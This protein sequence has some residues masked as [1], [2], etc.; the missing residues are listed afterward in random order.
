[1]ENINKEK[2]KDV[3]L[4]VRKSYRLLFEYQSRILNLAKY[5]GDYFSYSYNGG[6]PLYSAACPK[7]GKGSLDN[8]AWDWLN[9]YAYAFHFGEKQIKEQR[10]YFEIRIYS[11]TGFY[12]SQIKEQLKTETFLDE[13]SSK[14]KI[15]LI[16]SNLEWDPN[17]L[18]ENFNSE[19]DEYKMKNEDINICAKSYDLENFLDEEATNIILVNFTDY[20]SVNGIFIK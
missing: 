17:K 14:T 16:A 7:A 15:V 19:T 2:L 20:C 12:D 1:M 6:W 13:T 4:N 8:W 5:I 18:L 3:F 11:D 10:V 9:M